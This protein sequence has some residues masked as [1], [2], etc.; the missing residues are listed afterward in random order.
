M[1]GAIQVVYDMEAAAVYQ[2]A[3][4]SWDRI[5]CIL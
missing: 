3:A 1:K 2:A 5:V 4:F